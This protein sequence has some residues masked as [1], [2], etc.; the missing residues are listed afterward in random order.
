MIQIPVAKISIH[1]IIKDKSLE[2]EVVYLNQLT[3]I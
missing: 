2:I 1:T 3:Q